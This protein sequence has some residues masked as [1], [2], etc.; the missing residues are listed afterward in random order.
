[1][2]DQPARVACLS[3]LE[4]AGSFCKLRAPQ[5]SYGH[6][7]RDCGSS[8]G[9]PESCWPD[10]GAHHAPLARNCLAFRPRCDPLATSATFGGGG[11]A[12]AVFGLSLV[13]TGIFSLLPAMFILFNRGR[14]A[15]LAGPSLGETV[16]HARLSR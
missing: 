8:R 13:A 3:G 7:R 6:G 11:I 12:A 15:K 14:E 10:D 5:P 9:L 1:M 16:S 4:P 2:D